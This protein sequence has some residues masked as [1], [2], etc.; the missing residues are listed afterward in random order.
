MDNG[1]PCP[2]SQ[3]NTAS[4]FTTAAEEGLQ[5]GRSEGWPGQLGHIQPARACSF[6]Y[7]TYYIVLVILHEIFEQARM[8][9]P[10]PACT[11][12]RQA[13]R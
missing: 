10:S 8:L 6:Q 13:L 11:L 1:S 9:N 4:R 3:E 2:Q 5:D 12:L 7:S